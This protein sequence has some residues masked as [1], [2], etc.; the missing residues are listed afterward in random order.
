MNSHNMNIISN[1]SIII[2]ASQ[3]WKKIST[4]VYIVKVII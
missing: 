4:T 1:Q 3:L 2:C